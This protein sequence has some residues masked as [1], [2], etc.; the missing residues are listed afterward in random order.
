MSDLKYTDK[1]PIE[2]GDCFFVIVGNDQ[3]KDNIYHTPYGS[4]N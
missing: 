4:W 3:F 2:P 1:T